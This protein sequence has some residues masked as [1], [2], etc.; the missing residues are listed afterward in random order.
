MKQA[1]RFP[2]SKTEPLNVQFFQ[3]REGAR[4]ICTGSRGET[5]QQFRYGPLL[6]VEVLR[7][8]VGPEE[9]G[10]GGEAQMHAKKGRHAV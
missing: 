5:V 10:E 4:V 6:H 3:K 7:F 2:I 1:L 9:R 8:L